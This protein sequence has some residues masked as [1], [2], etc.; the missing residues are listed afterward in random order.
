MNLSALK[1][2]GW[3]CRADT[4][5][6]LTAVVGPVWFRSHSDPKVQNWPEI[7]P[8]PLE[9]HRGV[10]RDL[11]PPSGCSSAMTWSIWGFFGEGVHSCWSRL[12]IHLKPFF[13][14]IMPLSLIIEYIFYMNKMHVETRTD[15][16][17][18]PLFPFILFIFYQNLASVGPHFYLEDDG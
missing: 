3:A 9:Q 5:T 15:V 8:S 2:E 17:T 14:S 13:V 10:R 4:K 12:S 18:T 11:L 16:P 7:S 6:W 1:S